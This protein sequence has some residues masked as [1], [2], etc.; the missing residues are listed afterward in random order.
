VDALKSL[1]DVVFASPGWGIR[2]ALIKAPRYST[3]FYLSRT[4][5]RTIAYCCA[6]QFILRLQAEEPVFQYAPNYLTST[7]QPAS[8][9]ATVSGLRSVYTSARCGARELVDPNILVLMMNLR[10][11]FHVY[12]Q[13]PWWFAIGLNILY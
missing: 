9:D 5:P 13:W 7:P 3:S 4:H 8:N 1:P 11:C 10:Y 12:H 6:G 2:G